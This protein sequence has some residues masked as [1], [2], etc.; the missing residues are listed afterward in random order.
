MVQFSSNGTQTVKPGGIIQFDDVLVVG[1]TPVIHREGSGVITLPSLGGYGCSCVG[2]GYKVNFSGNIA[3]PTTPPAGETAA[4][5]PISLALAIGG[6]PDSGTE[7]IATPS[8]ADELANVSRSIIVATVRGC[9]AS[10]C[11]ENTSSGTITV[12]DPILVIDV[13][14]GAA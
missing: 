11:V 4:T 12:S 3:F 5:A 2:T 10:I 9:C 7:M 8:A 14:G 13:E 1:G 6:E